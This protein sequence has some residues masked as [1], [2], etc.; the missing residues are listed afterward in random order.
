MI[1]KRFYFNVGDTDEGR[2]GL[3]RGFFYGYIRALQGQRGKTFVIECETM[4]ETS[5]CAMAAS[6]E[7]PAKNK[8]MREYGGMDTVYTDPDNVDKKEAFIEFKVTPGGE[9]ELQKMFDIANKLIALD[10]N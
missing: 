5:S 9:Q 7:V 6:Y 10:G 4:D 8:R 2:I 3:M 1:S